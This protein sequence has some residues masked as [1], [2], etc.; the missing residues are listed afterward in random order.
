MQLCLVDAGENILAVFRTVQIRPQ[1]QA[2]FSPDFAEHISRFL[3]LRAVGRYI[4]PAQPY[5]S[6]RSVRGGL[7]NQVDFDRRSS[8]RNIQVVRPN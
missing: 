7:L 8:A 6:S 1:E 3:I 4:T 2:I 5:E